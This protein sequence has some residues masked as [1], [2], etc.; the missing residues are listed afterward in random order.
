MYLNA[1]AVFRLADYILNIL[2]IKHI[3]NSKLFIAYPIL[4]NNICSTHFI[5][6]S[7]F[8][9]FKNISDKLLSK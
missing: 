8:F 1:Y 5:D 3:E 9:S 2:P 6:T 7:N 4:Y